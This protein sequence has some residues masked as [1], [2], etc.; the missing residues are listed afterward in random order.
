MRV[1]EAIVADVQ[2]IAQ[3]LAD[4]TLGN[5]RERPGDPVYF[6]AFARM[7]DQPGNVI[8]VAEEG[9]TLIGCLQY[10]LIHGLSRAGSSRAQIEGVRVAATH[11]GHGVGEKL[12]QT[13]IDRAQGDGA[14]LIQLTTD[15]TRDEAKRFYERLGFEATHWGM[16]L[17]L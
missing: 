14:K 5:T 9:T 13:A 12:V 6:T 2:Q 11:R 1:R 8:L 17:S 3:L 10:T 7:A 16:K 15:L 4:D